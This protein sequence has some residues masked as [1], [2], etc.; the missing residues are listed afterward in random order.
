MKNTIKLITN[1]NII[2]DHINH[3]NNGTLRKIQL[4]QSNISEEDASLTGL[5][6]APAQNVVVTELL[7]AH[8]VLRDAAC[9][10]EGGGWRGEGYISGS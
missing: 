7:R 4:F 3:K 2:F 5:P 10:R 1:H 6:P 9:R 8:E